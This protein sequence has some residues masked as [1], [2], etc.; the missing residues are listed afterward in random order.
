MAVNPL[1]F[2]LNFPECLVA[3]ISL[4]RV[5]FTVICF[6]F[7]SIVPKYNFIPRLPYFPSPSQHIL[8]FF[9]PMRSCHATTFCSMTPHHL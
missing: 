5:M 8:F 2:S 3:V 6:T 4:A 1:K 9:R 7:F